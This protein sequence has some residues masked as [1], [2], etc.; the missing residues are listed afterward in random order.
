[1]C[2]FVCVATE[3]VPSYCTDG[4]VVNLSC[5]CIVF[6]DCPGVIYIIQ[7]TASAELFFKYFFK[8][9]RSRPTV[10]KSGI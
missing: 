2:A 8:L 7:I 3:M 10:F 5:P 1:M 6:S 9:G 4:L